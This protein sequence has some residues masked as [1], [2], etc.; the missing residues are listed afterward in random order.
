MYD[1]GI[2]PGSCSGVYL[3]ED[4]NDKQLA[5]GRFARLSFIFGIISL[6]GIVCCFPTIPFFAG[7]GMLFGMVSLAGAMFGFILIPA[8]GGLGIIFAVVSRGREKEFKG[9]AKHGMIMSVAGTVISVLLVTG[10]IGYS[11][12]YTYRE[13]KT[14]DKIVDEV[15]DSY[16]QM[17]ENAGMDVPPEIEDMLDKM[18]ELAE[19]LRNAD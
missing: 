12:Y 10:I 9:Q 16:E 14:N 11:A 17:F 4:S 13:L 3:M 8:I 1:A 5:A 2:A 19:Q 18:D 7:L 15:R 6:A